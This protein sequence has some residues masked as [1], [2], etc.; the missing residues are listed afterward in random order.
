MSAPPPPGQ[1]GPGGQPPPPQQ[2]PPPGYYPPQGGWGAPPPPPPKQNNT[3]KWLLAGVG[4]LL[5]IAIT[6]GVTVLVTRDGSG[7]DGPSTTTSA[8]GPP[9]A[10]ADDDGPIEIITSEPTCQAWIPL[11]NAGAA[12]QNNGWNDRDT[13]T[14]STDWTAGERSEHEA[15]AK[16]LKETADQSVALAR[17]TPH[18]VVRELYE[19]FIV[20][21]RAYADSIPTY[22]QADNYLARAHIAANNALDAICNS[23]TYGSA[24]QRSASAT[25]VEPPPNLSAPGNPADPKRVVSEASSFCEQLIDIHERMVVDTGAWADLDPNIPAA[26]WPSDRRSASTQTANAMNRFADDLAKVGQESG[27]STFEDLASFGA[28]YFH[29]YAAA[30]P[31]YV[32]VDSYILLA[33][34]RASNLLVSA[35]RAVSD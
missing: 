8:S 32:A 4:V 14:P 20:F 25:P 24:A 7:G 11:S 19:Q 27:S 26:D 22:T 15:V 17:Q 33:G 30:L 34:S 31:T 2:P 18:R 5:V 10:S 9:I 35:C 21:A 28:V 1:W 3:I 12:V 6:V 29:A 16:S 13:A 23:I